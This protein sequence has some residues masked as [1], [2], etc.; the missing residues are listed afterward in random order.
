KYSY[1]SKSK[2]LYKFIEEGVAIGAVKQISNDLKEEAVLDIIDNPT[3]LNKDKVRKDF[4]KNNGYDC[5][6]DDQMQVEKFFNDLDKNEE[7]KAA[8]DDMLKSEA[9]AVYESRK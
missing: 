5:D 6:I 2:R 7:A 4:I 9:E 1:K 3:L 8:F